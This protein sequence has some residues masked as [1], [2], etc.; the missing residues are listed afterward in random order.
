MSNLLN[1]IKGFFI[2]VMAIQNIL[3]VDEI[4][5]VI[6][7]AARKQHL[8]AKLFWPSMQF[9]AL[10]KHIKS[11]WTKQSSTAMF[12]M[13]HLIWQQHSHFPAE[14]VDSLVRL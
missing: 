6:S 5:D 8:K 12:S 11:T 10:N 14:D 9:S 2:N 7:T 13:H 1:I 3:L 4:G